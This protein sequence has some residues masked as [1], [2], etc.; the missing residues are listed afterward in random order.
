MAAKTVAFG[1]AARLR[2]LRGAQL[3][4]E[5]VAPTLGP[6]GRHVLL[7]QPFVPPKVSGHGYEIA[8]SLDLGD[9]LQ[10]IGVRA[11]R[12]VAWRTSD[13]VGD[14]TATAIVLASA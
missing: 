1:D 12:D 5:A 11:L 7:G 10:Q 8:Q 13:A 9:P 4:A 3:L 2:I 6:F 14:G